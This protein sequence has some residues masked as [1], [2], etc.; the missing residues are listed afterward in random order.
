MGPLRNAWKAR[1]KIARH[2][3]RRVNCSAFFGEAPQ[4]GGDGRK[5]PG[6]GFSFGVR[7]R[8]ADRRLPC[9]PVRVAI[10]VRNSGRLVIASRW[11]LGSARRTKMFHQL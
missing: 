1:D 2:F 4:E 8:H 5:R 3:C 6:G 7:A 9:V 10:A 11:R